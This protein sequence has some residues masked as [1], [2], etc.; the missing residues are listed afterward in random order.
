[1]RRLF[2][3]NLRKGNIN[4]QNFYFLIAMQLFC[5]LMRAIIEFSFFLIQ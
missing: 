3:F 2:V 1:M 5:M 4:L